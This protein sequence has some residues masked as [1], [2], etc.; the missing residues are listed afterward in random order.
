[1]RLFQD[2]VEVEILPD[3]AMCKLD[4]ELRSPLDIPDDECPLG[5]EFCSGECCYYDEDYDGT[6]RKEK[7]AMDN[8]TPISAGKHFYELTKKDDKNDTI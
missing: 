2:G 8:A 4:D 6:I 7:E 3:C 5:E 1:M